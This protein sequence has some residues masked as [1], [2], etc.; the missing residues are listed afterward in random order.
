MATSAS[1]ATFSGGEEAS[2]YVTR[3]GLTVAAF[4]RVDPT[5]PVTDISFLFRLPDPDQLEA[6]LATIDP[7]ITLTQLASDLSLGRELDG[8]YGIASPRHYLALRRTMMHDA[9]NG[10]YWS[11]L[12]TA[13][14]GI[15]GDGAKITAYVEARPTEL[16]PQTFTPTLPADG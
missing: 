13:L 3:L 14:G 7:S 8:V 11:Q 16:P 15:A 12:I 9:A 2:R 5:T 1:T 4:S 10:A 6:D